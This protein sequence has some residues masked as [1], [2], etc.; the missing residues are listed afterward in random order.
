MDGIARALQ[1][2]NQLDSPTTPPTRPYT[3]GLRGKVG[4]AANLSLAMPHSLLI[5]RNI[6]LAMFDCR[7]RVRPPYSSRLFSSQTKADNLHVCTY[8]FSLKGR[9]LSG[10]PLIANVV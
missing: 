8:A 1:H 3:H 9:N 7:K 4:N 5:G 2:N 10:P 6:F